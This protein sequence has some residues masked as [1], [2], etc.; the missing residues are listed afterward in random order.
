[1]D[2]PEGKYL[3]KLCKRGHD[4]EGTGRSLRN[5]LD[6]G[7]CCECKKRS[8]KEWKIRCKEKIR[9]W[10]HQ[11][12]LLNREEILRKDKIYRKNNREKKQKTN[13]L[14]Y[15]KNRASKKIYNQKWQIEN[16]VAYLEYQK[17]WNKNNREKLKE[18][19][20]L[21]RKDLTDNYIRGLLTK[22]SDLKSLNL[23]FSDIPDRIVEVYRLLIINHRLIM[24]RRNG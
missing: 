19:Q 14:W 5:K 1:M 24:R 12:Y 21:Y 22:R 15:A 9:Q 20:R 6:N 4:W 13:K 17:N 11:Y 23:K 16:K 10:Q 2:I 7:S 18:Y 3:R 8:D